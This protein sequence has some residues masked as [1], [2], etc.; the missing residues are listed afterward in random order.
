MAAPE[1]GLQTCQMYTVECNLG[2]QHIFNPLKDEA[3]LK[4]FMGES[5]NCVLNDGIFLFFFLEGGVFAKS[6]I[7]FLNMEFFNHQ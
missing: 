5:N 2:F 3:K 6:K 1:V 4:A 7:T